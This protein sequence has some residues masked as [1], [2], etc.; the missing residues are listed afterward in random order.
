[1]D[2]NALDKLRNLRIQL[3]F[4]DSPTSRAISSEANEMMRRSCQEMIREIES[5]EHR[6]HDRKPEEFDGAE[7]RLDD[8]TWLAQARRRLEAADA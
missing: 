4:C 6:S 1:M 2:A 8:V 7:R 3:A 5:G